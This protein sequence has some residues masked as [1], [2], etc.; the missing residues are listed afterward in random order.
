MAKNKG[1]TRKTDAG[2]SQ[3]TEQEQPESIETRPMTDADN[4]KRGGIIDEI[5]RNRR[6]SIEAELNE[7]R[8]EDDPDRVQLRGPAPGEEPEPATADPDAPAPEGAGG[9][10]A[11]PGK[12]PETKSPGEGEAPQGASSGPEP[13]TE[14]ETEPEPKP[15]ELMV[16]VSIDGEIKEV[17]A[18]AITVPTRVNG[19]DQEVGGQDLIKGFQMA[20]AGQQRLR[21]ANRRM[22]EA[23]R[24][25]TQNKAQPP[26]KDTPTAE[27][28][29]ATPDSD[30]GGISEGDA[31]AMARKLQFGDEAEVADVIR[32][33]Q[34]PAQGRGEPATPQVSTQEVAQQAAAITEE[35]QRYQ[36]D[37]ETVGEE[38]PEMFKDP[39]LVRVAAD[40]VHQI[41]AHDLTEAG[42]DLSGTTQEQRAAAYRA[43]QQQEMPGFRPNIDLFRL[44]AEATQTWTNTFNGAAGEAGEQPKKQDLAGKREA[45]RNAASPPKAATAF[46]A[47]PQTLKAPT[48]SQAVDTMRKARGQPVA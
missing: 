21:E 48:R 15:A 20:S 35:R 23:Q 19:A 37:L 45:K 18:T 22:Q 29:P 4:P 30:P 6:E 26:Q 44:A 32:Q 3:A 1:T 46:S 33:L 2:V 12:E 40:F 14:P 39:I 13:E 17:P 8:A 42:Y 10:E 43:E 16:R 7:D 5:A 27:P 47:G 38:H 41:R 9:A 11:E 24:L 28:D 31:L 34:S 25:E 36:K